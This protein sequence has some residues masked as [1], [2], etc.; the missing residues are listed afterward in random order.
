MVVAHK[1][2]KDYDEFTKGNWGNYMSQQHLRSGQQSTRS[3]KTTAHQPTIQLGEQPMPDLNSPDLSTKQILQLQ[4]SIGNQATMRLIN[5][6]PITALST[7]PATR[8]IQTMK[9]PTKK[10]QDFGY[11]TETKSMFTDKKLFDQV[12][13]ACNTTDQVEDVIYNTEDTLKKALAQISEFSNEDHPLKESIK[14]IEQSSKKSS[15]PVST[16]KPIDVEGKLAS[17]LLEN[18][19]TESD[20]G[21]SLLESIKSA[22][23]TKDKT[24]IS[25]IIENATREKERLLREEQARQERIQ[26]ANGVRQK[27]TEKRLFDSD[28][29]MKA[30]LNKV[31]QTA[32]TNNKDVSFGEELSHDEALRCVRQWRNKKSTLEEIGL[33]NPHAFK[34]QDKGVKDSYKQQAFKRDV[35]TWQANIIANGVNV[36]LD[37][38]PP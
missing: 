37:C 24:R 28:E 2:K 12:W 9:I 3:N 30:I 13:Q 20:L 14:F 36:H 25:E 21:P 8:V 11:Y 27:V 38:S 32:E 35:G 6:K 31:I 16:P 4:G 34:P 10:H 19:L 5:R 29:N 1:L 18:G 22:I 15:Q 33:S 7:P 23:S 17:L 26:W